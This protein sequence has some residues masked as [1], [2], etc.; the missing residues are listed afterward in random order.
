MIPL[1][2]PPI[3]ERERNRVAEV[4]SSGQ[5]ADGPE[6]RAFESA[7]AEFCGTE[8][9]VATSNGTTALH[10]AL[11]G[12]GVGEGDEVLTTPFSFVATANA[13]RH[14]GAEPVFVDVN[15]RTYNLDPGAVERYLRQT[16]SDPE[17]IV[18]VH[19]FGLPADV[20]RLSALAAEHDLTVIEDACQAHGARVDGEPV[21]S[22]G[23]AGCFSFY[24]SKNLTTGEGGMV[25]TDDE[26]LAK[27]V[28]RFVDHGQNRTG[29][30]VESGHNFRMTSI[31]GAI[32]REQL[33]RLPEFNRRRREN[34]ATLT[35]QLS[36]LP[37]R[38]PRI[39]SDRHHVFNL[40]T[41]LCDERDE[42]A[43]YLEIRGVDSG[44]YYP[45]PIHREPAFDDVSADC[46]VAE[47]LAEAVLSLPVHPGLED[48]DVRAITDAVGGFYGE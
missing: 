42:L 6:V 22:V 19:L 15:P 25:T 8:Y 39:P 5:L 7:F 35:E 38:T 43:E 40:Y 47:R 12:A 44:V 16:D 20:D 9:A 45:T 37:L 31:A 13:I 21:G 46:P 24:P 14:A 33:R 34:A 2:D 23:D 41:V 30:H 17:A 26:A 1:V 28:R 27:R 18:P 32:G 36:T 29:K 3:G 48:A 4:I 11:V 10:A